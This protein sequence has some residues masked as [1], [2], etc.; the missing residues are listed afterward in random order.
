MAG[1][2]QHAIVLA[3]AIAC[4]AVLLV[5]RV[6]AFRGEG[7]LCDGCAHQRDPLP[8]P[9]K[10]IPVSALLRRRDRAS[11]RPLRNGLRKL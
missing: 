5:R 6:R 9:A 3:T 2:W 11:S 7:T 4:A 1:W 8:A 10:P